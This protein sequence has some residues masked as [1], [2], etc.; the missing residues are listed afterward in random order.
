M[1]I[2][3]SVSLLKNEENKDKVVSLKNK[4]N[5]FNLKDMPFILILQSFLSFNVK[6]PFL[7]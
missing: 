3:V 7:L 2:L 4:L 6:M 1:S 5:L